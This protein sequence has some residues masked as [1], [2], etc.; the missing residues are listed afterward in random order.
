MSTS[1][2]S[3]AA[4]PASPDDCTAP[5]AA[6]DFGID[7]GPGLVGASGGRQP[8]DARQVQQFAC[9]RDVGNEQMRQRGPFLHERFG[10]GAKAGQRSDNRAAQSGAQS[11][12]H[13]RGG[14]YY[15]EP[16]ERRLEH[17]G[18]PCRCEAPVA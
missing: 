5:S 7:R 17:A 3:A 8:D 16:H 2:N 12:R 14:R 9:G 13:R 10:L 11:T 6:F 4:W 1:A 15:G 18:Y